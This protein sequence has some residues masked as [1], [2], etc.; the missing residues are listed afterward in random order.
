MKKILAYTSP[1]FLAA[2]LS[3]Q[4]TST[5][6]DDITAGVSTAQTIFNSVMGI[7]VLAF[8]AMLAIKFARKGIK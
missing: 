2:S 6:I 3:A 5:V 7:S 8:V 4:E 1:L